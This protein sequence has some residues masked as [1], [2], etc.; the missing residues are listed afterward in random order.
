MEVK[1]YFWNQVN[2]ICCKVQCIFK[3]IVH[4]IMLILSSFTHS[5][6]CSKP[7]SF[8][9]LLSTKEDNLKIVGNKTVDDSHRFPYFEYKLKISSFVLVNVDIIFG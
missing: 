3:R 7:V 4:P 1:L 9:L 5:S 6:S 2:L 8:F